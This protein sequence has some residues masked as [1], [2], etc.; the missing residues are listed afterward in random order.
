MYTFG[1]V[2][3]IS[4]N[5][6]D[7]LKKTLDES[8]D[9]ALDMYS[10]INYTAQKNMLLCKEEKNN[11]VSSDNKFI[12]IISD[13]TLTTWHKQVDLATTQDVKLQDINAVNNDKKYA[14]TTHELFIPVYAAKNNFSIYD[15]NI[16]VAIKNGAAQLRKIKIYV[17]DRNVPGDLKTQIVGPGSND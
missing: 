2:E 10:N 16:I 14:I 8:L 1:N 5:F 6:D 3:K 11:I 12:N 13:W 4:V 7:N 9:T 15:N 17:S